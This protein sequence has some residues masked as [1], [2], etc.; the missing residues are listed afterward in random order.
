MTNSGVTAL[1]FASWFCLFERLEETVETELLSLSFA[2][3]VDFDDHNNSVQQQQSTRLKQQQQHLASVELHQTEAE[4]DFALAAPDTLPHNQNEA[5]RA[6]TENGRKV[7][8]VK[9]D[10]FISSLVKRSD[11]KEEFLRQ[12]QVD[13]WAAGGVVLRQIQTPQ[14]RMS[15]MAVVMSTETT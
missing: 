1:V 4:K 8:P 11:V 10:L 7:E 14:R 2:D 3:T 12:E 15:R 9:E 5:N 6:T 13:Q